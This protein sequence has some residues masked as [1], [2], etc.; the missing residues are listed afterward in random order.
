MKRSAGGAKHRATHRTTGKRH[1]GFGW[2]ERRLCARLN[3]GALLQ[4]VADTRL[5]AK[6]YRA[7]SCA[8]SRATGH[9]RARGP[10]RTPG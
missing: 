5:S 2:V 9:T 6:R 7:L 4:H 3:T 10:D 8:G 1:R